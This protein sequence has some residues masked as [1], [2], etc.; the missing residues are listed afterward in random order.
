MEV[1]ALA[2]CRDQV[3]VTGEVGEQAQ[4]DL[5]VV[6]GQE[7]GALGHGEG[8]AHAMAQLRACGDVLQVG[9]GAREAPRG[10]HRLVEGGVDAP[11]A[12]H[13]RR[14]RV[15]VGGLDLGA[16][17]VLEHLGHDRVVGGEV[18]EDLG[19]GGVE[20]ALGALEPVGGEPQ[21]VEE[22]VAQLLGGVDVEVLAGL[23]VDLLDHRVDLCA[24]LGGLRREH[25]GV[26]PQ[27][28]ALHLGEHRQ[29]RHL[30]IVEQA[31]RAV[32]LELL[33]KDCDQALGGHG[34]ERC[35]GQLL[36]G[37]GQ[38]VGEVGLGEL[39]HREAAAL[40]VE[41]VGG[42][43]DVED[44][45]RVNR[46]G[47][48]HLRQR[49]VGGGEHVQQRLD[50][51]RGEPP[52]A[53]QTRERRVGLVALEPADL[54]ARGR[55]QHVG[56]AEERPVRAVV[57]DR[58]TDPAAG[59]DGLVERRGGLVT[60]ERGGQLQRRGRGLVVLLAQRGARRG[61][62]A[63][64][65]QAHEARGHAREAERG[66]RARDLGGVE[67]GEARVGE[68]QLDGGVG[69]DRGHTAAHQRVVDVGAQVL[70][71][72]A[73]DLVGVRDDLV[74]AAVLHDERGGLLGADARHAGDVV[75]GVALEAVEVRHELGR[76]AVVEVLDRRWVHDR[77][78]RDALLGGDDLH[79]VGGELVHVAVAGEQQHRVAGRLAAPGQRAQDVVA[80]PALELG[81]RHVER[82]QQVLDH[83][84]L[85]VQRRVHRR[86]L[87]LVLGQHLHAHARL[88][89]IE[90]ADH[91][92]GVKRVHELDEHVEEAK[93]RVGG[94][95]VRRVHG[96]ADRVER[97]VHEGVS[98]DDG[99]RAGLGRLGHGVPLVL[100]LR[101]IVGEKHPRGA[102][103]PTARGSS[104]QFPALRLA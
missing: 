18:A 31:R 10:G 42:D 76:D 45:R 85:L 11:V 20:A 26:D 73:L 69:A 102:G 78:V 30:H 52:R 35:G 36:G 22:H 83:R 79:A 43:A 104:R 97:T 99:D 62:G 98:V 101:P 7:H 46:A 74:E 54:L 49:G 48:E 38:H 58:G 23:R 12:G 37:L 77:H 2:E 64:P 81:H 91:A 4:L 39:R 28:Q 80:L 96:L 13:E 51:A 44:A 33:A 82:A 95:P 72:L 87:R 67:G 34:V 1:C 103:P 40:G 92:V 56:E 14:Q 27:A 84:E 47:R 32:L 50:V 57:I 75:G 88:A 100:S 17:A 16:L 90:G 61:D 19:I 60:G 66:E 59:S 29:Q 41:Q 53:E 93:E 8:L 89:L 21:H 55:P 9:V 65:G 3:L 24:E 25:A 70:A 6:A 15:E 71:H 68:V 86:A 63:V 5:G 94:A